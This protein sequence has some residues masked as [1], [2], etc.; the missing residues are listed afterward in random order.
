MADEKPKLF[1][2]WMETTDEDLV[3]QVD[4]RGGWPA[5]AGS[6]VMSHTGV[7]GE[8]PCYF[9]ARANVRDE[10]NTTVLTA[11]QYFWL[12]VSQAKK[13]EFAKDVLRKAARRLV[14]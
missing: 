6:I 3:A 14:A 9:S 4:A 8:R 1:H 12:K 13:D 11:D 2:V 7:G 10:W 5:K